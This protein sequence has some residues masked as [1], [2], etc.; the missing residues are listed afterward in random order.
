VAVVDKYYRRFAME[1]QLMLLIGFLSASLIF[2]L[3]MLVLAGLG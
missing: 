1:G 3:G 2:C